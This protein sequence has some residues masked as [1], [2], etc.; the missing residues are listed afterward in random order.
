MTDA[1]VCTEL[2]TIA[3]AR[4][5]T[6]VAPNPETLG[7]MVRRLRLTASHN[8]HLV[9][10]ARAIGLTRRA[11][12]LIES[13]RSVPR[14]STLDKLMTALALAADDV[15]HLRE[16]R[17]AEQ[18]Q[19]VGVN[20]AGR[21][22]KQIPRLTDLLVVEA[23]MAMRRAGLAVDEATRIDLHKRFGDVL[24]FVLTGVTS[25]QNLGAQSFAKSQLRRENALSVSAPTVPG[26][27]A[28]DG[29]LDHS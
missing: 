16:L 29:A 17:D 20:V 15:Q 21:D 6:G 2:A 26:P 4:A 24:R 5:A 27:Q 11:L 10:L 25:G 9:D 19:R 8:R 3:S 12:E 7:Q 23:V 22:A 28:R 1:I 14:L 18:A 13:G